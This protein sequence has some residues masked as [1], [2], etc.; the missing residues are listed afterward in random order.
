MPVLIELPRLGSQESEYL[1]CNRNVKKPFVYFVS[2][3]KRVQHAAKI[4]AKKIV[5]ITS[6]SEY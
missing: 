6:A 5:W 4:S 3:P 1:Q 2:G